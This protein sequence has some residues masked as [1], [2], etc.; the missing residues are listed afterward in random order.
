MALHD[1]ENQ[2]LQLPIAE[3]RRLA[4]LLL[5][6]ITAETSGSDVA[7]VAG[8]SPWLQSLVGVISAADNDDYLMYLQDK[9]Q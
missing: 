6:S 7:A 8:L 1:I 2:A 9:Y 3:R 5:N 4:Q